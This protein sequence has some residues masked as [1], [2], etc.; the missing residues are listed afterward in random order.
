[1]AR[2]STAR[3]FTLVELMIVVAI[4]GILAA[5]A[6]YGLKKYVLAAKTSEPMEI[7]N[8]IRIAQE[9]YKDETFRYL[10][11]TDENSFFPFAD[12]NALKNQSLGWNKGSSEILARWRTLG[13]QPSTQVQ[14]GYA[15]LAEEGGDVPRTK[16]L[17]AEEDVPIG[18]TTGWWYVVRAAADRD[19]NG[20]LAILIGSSFSDR[21]FVENDTE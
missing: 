14:F 6:V 15:C 20:K 12:K 9:S 7:I 8:S 21:I 18:S 11:V 13:V 3:G 19:P 1:M 2:R 16:D 17:G 5:L 4:I 10:P